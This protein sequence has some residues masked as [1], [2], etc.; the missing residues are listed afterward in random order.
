MG[1]TYFFTDAKQTGVGVG[2]NKND[3][4]QIGGGTPNVYIDVKSSDEAL[5]KA[6]SLGGSIAVPETFI[7]DMGSFAFIK[8]PDPLSVSPSSRPSPTQ[9]RVPS[10]RMTLP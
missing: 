7:P 6:Q 4:A 5:A 1:E 8:A 10:W 3:R 9:P 2:I